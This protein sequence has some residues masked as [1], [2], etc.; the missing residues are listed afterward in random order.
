MHH[1]VCT[2]HSGESVREEAVWAGEWESDEQWCAIQT[3]AGEHKP[4]AQVNVCA[5]THCYMDSIMCTFEDLQNIV[6][7]SFV[8]R[9]SLEL[10]IHEIRNCD[11][12]CGIRRCVSVCVCRVHE[13]EEQLKEQEAR[14]EQIMESELRRHRDAFNKLE[15]DK[16]TEIEM[17]N[18]R[19]THTHSQVI[20]TSLLSHHIDD[21]MHLKGSYVT[22]KCL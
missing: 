5:H 19:Y 15:R 12:K 9:W 10:D 8:D 21:F 2:W 20:S 11:I 14:A 4:S 13:L 7:P 1:C 22:F 6:G 17:L 3:Q 18:N 16:T